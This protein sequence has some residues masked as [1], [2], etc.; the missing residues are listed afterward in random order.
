M[1]IVAIHE[2]ES[3]WLLLVVK[4]LLETVAV[5]AIVYKDLAVCSCNQ[6]FVVRFQETDVERVKRRIQTD[7]ILNCQGEGSPTFNKN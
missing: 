3:W 7:E 4:L 2:N 1:D 6:P 5:L